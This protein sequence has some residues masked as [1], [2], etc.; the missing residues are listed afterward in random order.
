MFAL[1]SRD[2]GRESRLQ[3]QKD[4][5]EP[6]FLDEAFAIDFLLYLKSDSSLMRNFA[7]SFNIFRWKKRQVSFPKRC[8]L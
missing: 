3:V 8:Q 5:R 7:F 2:A 6:V 1:T 4:R